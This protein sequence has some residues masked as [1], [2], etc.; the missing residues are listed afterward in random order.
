MHQTAEEEQTLETNSADGVANNSRS[1]AI[2]VVSGEDFFNVADTGAADA[3]STDWLRHAVDAEH[4]HEDTG[5]LVLRIIEPTFK[6]LLAATVVA[7]ASALIL[8]AH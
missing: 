7:W 8:F 4:E 1:T 3:N 2:I 6:F 5:A